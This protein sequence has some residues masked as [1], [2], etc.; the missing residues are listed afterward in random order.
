MKINDK[1]NSLARHSSK[2]YRRRNKSAIKNIAIHHSATT[3]GSAESFANYHVNNL[4]W[5]GI[6]YHYVVDRDGNID[7]CHDLE[8]VSYHVGNSNGIAVGICMIGDFTQQ[9]PTDAQYKA[10]LE[11]TKWLMSELKLGINAVWGHN[12]FPQNFTTCPVISMD[13]FRSDL[14][15]VEE[16]DETLKLTNYQWSTLEK[17]VA[18]LLKDKVIT[19]QAWLTKVKNKSLTVSELAWLNNMI[20]I[21][22]KK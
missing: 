2:T 21:R 12:Q 10:T 15:R 19:D 1:R 14:T 8:V 5:P 17:N 13:K 4:G 9:K 7:W 6:G 22:L 18:E 16:D 3:S 20:V 11:L